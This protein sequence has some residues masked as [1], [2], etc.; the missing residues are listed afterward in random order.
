MNQKE[1]YM[2]NIYSYL[3][4]R[5]DLNFSES[6]FNDVDSLVLSLISYVDF[7]SIVPG[8]DSKESITIKEA[9]EKYFSTKENL[10]NNK[11][12]TF[13]DKPPILLQQ[14]ADTKRFGNIR[15]GKYVNRIDTLKEKQFSASTFKLNEESIY[16]AYRGTDATII[17]WKED[18]NMCFNPEVPAQKEA[19]EYLENSFNLRYKNLRLG[20]HSKGGN[21]A[22]YSGMKCNRRIRDRILSVH[23]F[24]GPG[25]NM[26]IL[27]SNDYVNLTSRITNFNPQA[28][29]IGLLLESVGERKVVRSS[30]FG[31]VQQHDAFWWEV[32][33]LGFSCLNEFDKS[34][35]LMDSII[36]EWINKLDM[37]QRESFV[38]ALFSI[39]FVSGIENISDFSKIS[40]ERIKVFLK[41]LNSMPVEAKEILS[42]S[43]KLF[44]KE[45][46]N[47]VKKELKDNFRLSPGFINKANLRV[48]SR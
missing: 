44:F 11:A 2:E 34:S 46:R 32:N 14:A 29:I 7:N 27:K 36:K 6:A 21:L 26:E 9:S 37:K 16:I 31:G 24:D 1:V 38:D 4:W 23:N 48:L 25:F 3:K 15:F 18:F 43:L 47:A 28:S 41:S 8:I 22:I 40:N 17:G 33:A 12:A 10:K 39:L 35:I 20:G 13:L 45:T 42:R 30:Q 19:V 5:G